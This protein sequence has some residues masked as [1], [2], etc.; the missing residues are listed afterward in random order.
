MIVWTVM[1]THY[2]RMLSQA[3]MLHWRRTNVVPNTS[4]VWP[5]IKPQPLFV[6]LP[7]D[8]PINWNFPLLCGPAMPSVNGLKNATVFR[9]RSGRSVGICNSGDLHRRNHCVAPTSKTRKP[10]S[11][12]WNTTTLQFAGRPAQNVLKS[13]GATK[14][15]CVRTL[16]PDAVMV[17]RD[18]HQSFPEPVSGL[19]A[20][21]SRRSPTEVIWP[22]W[23]SKSGLPEPSWS[24]FFDAWS[25]RKQAEGFDYRWPSGYH[26]NLKRYVSTSKTHS[27]V[28]SA[29]DTA[30]RW[31][32]TTTQ[33]GC[34]DQ[35]GRSKASQTAW[36]WCGKFG[37]TYEVRNANQGSPKI[38]FSIRMSS[39]QQQMFNKSKNN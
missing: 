36:K 25:N 13:I 34:Q 10:S 35:C 32:R 18:I 12:G 33:S 26:S 27:G 28:L 37:R 14:W 23:F 22:L 4:L 5:V 38:I 19:A 3:A 15:E 30:L 1:N 39:M 24:N 9:F 20:I 8:V 2:G 11:V 7:T 17:S 6:W 21:W 31:I 16:R 29:Q